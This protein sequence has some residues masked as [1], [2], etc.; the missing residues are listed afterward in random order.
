MVLTGGRTIDSEGVAEHWRIG[1]IVVYDS[2]PIGGN[3]PSFVAQVTGV[4]FY[5][6]QV[7]LD[8][9]IDP[10]KVPNHYRSG[11]K[12]PIISPSIVTNLTLL[13]YF[14]I[15]FPMNYVKGTML[16]GINR[17]LP[18]VYHHVSEHYFIKWL[19]MWLVMG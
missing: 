1:I 15:L 3:I 10:S 8:G 4:G 16:P 14:L 19:G 9:G 17:L 11:P 2:N 18:D 6:E 12:L 13:Y 7:W 5:Y